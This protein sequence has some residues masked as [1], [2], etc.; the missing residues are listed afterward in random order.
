MT[1]LFC[2]ICGKETKPQSYYDEFTHGKIRVE[3]H[4]YS[5]QEKYDPDEEETKT[6]LHSTDLCRECKIELLTHAYK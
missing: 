3:I 2:D 6:T 4:Y 5:T 1:K